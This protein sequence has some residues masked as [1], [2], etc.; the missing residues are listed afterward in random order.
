M[1]EQ[2][3]ARTKPSRSALLLRSPWMPADYEI[4][5]IAA[6]QGLARGD[7]TADQQRRALDWIINKAAGTY[8]MSFHPGAG[9]GDRDTAFAEGR[10]F[11]GNQIVKM[12]KISLL[13]LRGREDA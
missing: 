10:R 12:L 3:K 4:A 13:A 8:E 1:P 6:I 11:T 2:D 7:A 9:D 5:D